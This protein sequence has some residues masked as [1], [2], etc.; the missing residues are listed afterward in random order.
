MP[1]RSSPAKTEQVASVKENSANAF[2]K[3]VNVLLKLHADKSGNYKQLCVDL[4]KATQEDVSTSF[5][6]ILKRRPSSKTGQG[7][8]AEAIYAMLKVLA[9]KSGKELMTNYE[10]KQLSTE[11]AQTAHE[12]MKNVMESIANGEELMDA[13]GLKKYT[14]A[15][16]DKMVKKGLAMA[17]E[18]SAL[19]ER[20]K[21]LDRHIAGDES[22]ITRVPKWP[23]N[24]DELFQNY[25]DTWD[26]FK[27]AHSSR[28]VTRKEWKVA[29]AQVRNGIFYPI[30][31]ASTN[32]EVTN[33][34]ME[35][36]N[37]IYI[38]GNHVKVSSKARIEMQNIFESLMVKS[39]KKLDMMTVKEFKEVL[40]ATK[41]EMT[42][43]GLNEVYIYSG[44]REIEKHIHDIADDTPLKHVPSMD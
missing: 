23:N 19:P 15:I 35:L 6:S 18:F 29:R 31:P 42:K 10:Y 37:G 12:E 9:N 20:E 11:L 2:A 26:C 24:K 8:Y 43:L 40:Q 44:C 25:N 28:H 1:R 3:E 16:K 34:K 7:W 30:E 17:Y 22:L 36:G 39:G 13:V 27:C 41:V 21:Y 33:V 4:D 38:S 32:C 14:L 5:A